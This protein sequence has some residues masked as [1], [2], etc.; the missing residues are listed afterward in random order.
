MWLP[1][2]KLAGEGRKYY[3]LYD[4]ITPELLNAAFEKVKQNK[5]SGGV[6]NETIE[7]LEIHKEKSL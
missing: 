4:K 7:L 5:G 1:K 2:G 3:S 6:D